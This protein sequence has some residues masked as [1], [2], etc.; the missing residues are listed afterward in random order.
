MLILQLL[1]V[2]FY[3]YLAAVNVAFMVRAVL[4][5]I[6]PEGDNLFLRVAA[7]MTEVFVVPFR[8]LFNKKG[9]FSEL[10]LDM[11]LFAGYTSA[12]LLSVLV[13][14]LYENLIW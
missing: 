4:S 6:M 12:G 9:W 7:A 1:F 13:V 8:V 10:P 3:Y 11:A 14:T 5:W 2:V